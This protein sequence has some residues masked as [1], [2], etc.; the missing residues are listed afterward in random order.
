MQKSIVAFMLAV[1][2]V[3]TTQAAEPKES[4]P[5]F[6]GVAGFSG[7]DDDGLGDAYSVSLD[8]DSVAFGI[9]GGYKLLK[10]LALEGRFTYL[11][12]GGAETTLKPTALTANV[13][14]ILP[15]GS[16]GTELFGQVGVGGVSINDNLSNAGTSNLDNEAVGT[17]GVGIR[18]Y[19][20]DTVALSA[21]YDVYGWQSK[22][23]GEKYDF[24]VGA[25]LFGLQ[26]QF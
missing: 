9:F 12:D 24:T 10:Y 16:S 13:V 15:L 11:G 18:V 3:A 25:L 7:F 19:A 26:W 14:G 22:V 17:V 4:G 2:A 1:L 5:Y 23:E 6:G 20:T 8:N 21:Q